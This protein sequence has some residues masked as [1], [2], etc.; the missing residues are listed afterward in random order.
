M[1][2]RKDQSA[3]GTFFTS[4]E[5]VGLAG[6][7]SKYASPGLLFCVDEVPAP[8]HLLRHRH[9]GGY[10]LFEGALVL[11]QSYRAHSST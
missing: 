5:N 11:R 9:A 7:A 4:E 10:Q 2:P 3:P 6:W 8:R 1:Q